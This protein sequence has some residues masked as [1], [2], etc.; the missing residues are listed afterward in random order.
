MR[1]RNLTGG[2]IQ[3]QQQEGQGIGTHGTLVVSS[4]RHT[5]IIIVIVTGSGDMCRKGGT[6]AASSISRRQEIPTL[7]EARDRKVIVVTSAAEAARKTDAKR[8]RGS[9]VVRP[10][11]KT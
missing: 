1:I 11:A 7:N 2:Q 6:M 10:N 4:I 9:E 5:T 8:V 3:Q